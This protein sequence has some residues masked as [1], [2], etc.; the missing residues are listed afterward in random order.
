M[1]VAG[2]CAHSFKM[3]KSD[4]TLI[5]WTCNLCHSGPHWS[6][7]ECRR[8]T[9]GKM[10]LTVRGRKMEACRQRGGL[11]LDALEGPLLRP[12]D[13]AGLYWFIPTAMHHQTRNT[14][15]MS[16]RNALAID[17]SQDFF[18]SDNIGY[19]FAGFSPFDSFTF[20]GGRRHE[21]SHATLSV[22]DF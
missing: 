3:I 1:A 15:R 6:I 17:D 20:G 7:F 13:A 14:T 9:A 19:L 12:S 4:S 21:K 5:Q 2:P 16:L 18:G 11:A 22:F 10:V 8:P